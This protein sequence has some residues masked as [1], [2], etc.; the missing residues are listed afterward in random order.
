MCQQ[1]YFTI[2]A[3]LDRGGGLFCSTKCYHASRVRPVEERFWEKVRKTDTCWLWIGGHN[4]KN[5]KRKWPYGMLSKGG[6]TNE[7]YRAHEFSW[8]L[9]NGPVPEGSWVLHKCDNT[10]CV[11]PDH[12][13]LGTP[14]DN[15]ADMMKKDRCTTRKLTQAQVDVIRKDYTHGSTIASL[16]KRFGVSGGAVWNI[17]HNKSWKHR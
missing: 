6:S 3:E 9:H 4:G 8:E 12:L 7:H 13:F 10:L 17:V 5:A 14:A 1:E 2:Q 16:A 15:T 11:N